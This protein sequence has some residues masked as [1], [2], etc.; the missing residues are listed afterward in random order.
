MYSRKE[1]EKAN[2]S[3]NCPIVISYSETLK[4]NI[5]EL[6]DVEF[7]NPFLPL[8]KKGLSKRFMEIEEFKKY[9]FTKSELNNAIKKPE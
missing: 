4:N 7:I 3:F 1:D 2:N 6:K 8:D 5:E 9:K